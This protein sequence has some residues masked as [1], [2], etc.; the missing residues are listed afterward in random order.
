MGSSQASAADEDSFQKGLALL[1]SNDAAGAIEAFKAAL[2]SSPND[3]SILTNLGI[4]CSRAGQKGWA[5]AFLRQARTLGSNWPETSQALTFVLSQL[6]VKELPHELSLWETA[7][8]RAL[9]QAQAET[10]ATV[11]A[12]CLL[13]SGFLLIRHLTARRRSQLNEEVPPGLGLLQWS[14]FV[15]SFLVGLLLWAKLVDQSIVRATVVADKVSAVSAP[16]KDAPALFDLSAGLEVYVHDKKDNFYQV[17]YPGGSTG[18]VPVDNV[19]ITQ[20]KEL[21]GP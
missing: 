1:Q 6:E 20:S 21:I 7:H 11:W 19:Y 9:G 13:V 18:W 17:Q 16:A 5:I 15:L 14:S 2:K 10:L 3:V 12:L 4:A 8:E